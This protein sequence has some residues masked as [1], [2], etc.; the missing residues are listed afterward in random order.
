MEAAVWY[1][2]YM[3]SKFSV[4]IIDDV[5]A[6]TRI[7]TNCVQNCSLLTF[8]PVLQNCSEPEIFFNVFVHMA[9]NY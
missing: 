6:D 2:P 1:L 7:R 3:P 9:F 4:M 5:T 8:R